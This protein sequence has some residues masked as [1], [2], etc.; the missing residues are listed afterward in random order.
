MLCMFD[1]TCPL[2]RRI[3]AIIKNKNNICYFWRTRNDILVV[4]Q[5]LSLHVFLFYKL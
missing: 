5:S 3:V 2:R 4:L 1:W